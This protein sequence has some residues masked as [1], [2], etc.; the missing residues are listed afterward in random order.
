MDDME[1]LR[2]LGI[3]KNME[4]FERVRNKIIAD[5]LASF[6]EETRRKLLVMQYELDMKRAQMTPEQFMEYIQ[7]QARFNVQKISAAMQRITSILQNEEP[8]NV[9][10]L[11]DYKQGALY[12]KLSEC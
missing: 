4:E 9:T 10:Y 1:K 6:P 12:K 3:E 5:F 11:A 2:Q 7:A 8:A